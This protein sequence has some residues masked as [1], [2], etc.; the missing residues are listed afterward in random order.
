MILHRLLKAYHNVDHMTFAY[1]D[2]ILS[3]WFDLLSG[4]RL[5][6]DG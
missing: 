2:L 4:W 5:Y 6:L 3:R 1:F